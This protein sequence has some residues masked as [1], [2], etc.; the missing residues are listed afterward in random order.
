MMF[1]DHNKLLTSWFYV[2]ECGLLFTGD[3]FYV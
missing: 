3:D 1:L 2:T